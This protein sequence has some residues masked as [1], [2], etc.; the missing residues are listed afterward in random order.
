MRRIKEKTVKKVYAPLHD[1]EFSAN[2]T[3][4]VKINYVT[5]KKDENETKTD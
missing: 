5:R 2:V 1:V 4:D 3:A